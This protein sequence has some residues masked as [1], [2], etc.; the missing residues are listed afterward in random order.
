MGRPFFVR[1]TLYASR[2][3]GEFSVVVDKDTGD[4]WIKMGACAIP[5][6]LD[7]FL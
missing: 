2:Y 7:S 6:L 4:L 5:Y 3:V 1:A